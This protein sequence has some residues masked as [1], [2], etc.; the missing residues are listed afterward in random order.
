MVTP[1]NPA[2]DLKDSRSDMFELKLV[3][4][5]Y[6]LNAV[7]I[8]MLRLFGFSL[9]TLYVLLYEIFIADA[10]SPDRY[11]LFIAVIATYTL[12]SWLL[13]RTFYGSTGKTDLGVVFLVLDIFIILWVIYFSGAD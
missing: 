4:D 7:L 10:F 1:K 5:E 6:R 9:L 11:G 3:K 12:A 2:D 13:L 8:P